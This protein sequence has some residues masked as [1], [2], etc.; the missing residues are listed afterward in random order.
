MY[1]KQL[2]HTVVL[3]TIAQITYCYTIHETKSVR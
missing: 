1:M 2:I 3:N